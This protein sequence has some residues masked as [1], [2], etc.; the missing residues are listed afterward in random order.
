MKPSAH[1][2]T[3]SLLAGLAL[4]V[5]A[6]AAPEAAAP[7]AEAAAPEAKAAP[8]ADAKAEA[9]PFIGLG[10]S[11]VPSFLG[12]H[13]KLPADS[14]V[15]VRDLA[16]DGPAAKAG[17]E[18][19][20]VITEVDGKA[21]ASHQDMV[22][23][24]LTKKPGEEVKLKV[25]HEGTAG[26]KSVTLGERP[27]GPVQ[28][29]E[30]EAKVEVGEA[31]IEIPA[32][33]G[34]LPPE[35]QKKIREAIENGVGGGGIQR[36]Q[37]I[38]GNGGANGNVPGGFNFKMASS[39]NLMDD[40]GSVEMKDTGDGKEVKVRDKAGKEV[41]SGPW[42]TDQDKAA[43]PPEIR[44]R[45]DRLNGGMLPGMRIQPLPEPEPADEPAAK[46]PAKDAAPKEGTDPAPAK[47]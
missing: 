3:T 31:K 15:L 21:V 46:E 33:P 16:P 8:E 42:D 43:A 39:I 26:E 38:P 37:I 23:Q 25:I 28:A 1:L 4:A 44:E 17:V 5:H 12:K 13:L 45:I 32:L 18:I 6:T 29:N 30:V 24:I 36:L 27:A 20:D 34:N 22:D 14:G 19:D 10:T 40:Q 35:M 7:A 11:D 47:P 2:L 9:K 41:W